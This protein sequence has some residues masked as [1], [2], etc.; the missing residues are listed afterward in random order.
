[1]VCSEMKF[2]LPYLA[3]IAGATAFDQY[4]RSTLSEVNGQHERELITLDGTVTACIE[5]KNGDA[6]NGNSFVL[7]DCENYD[8]G[9]DEV[10]AMALAC[11]DDCNSIDDPGILMYQ[12]RLDPTKC[13]QASHNGKI[14][15]G[16]WMRVKPCNPTNQLQ[17][18]V[19]VMG[20]EIQLKDTNLCVSFRGVNP[21]V[22]EDHILLQDCNNIGGAGWSY[23]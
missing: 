3:L 12:T 5:V 21:N 10:S 22:N 7:G 2:L 19:R 20:D 17:H 16:T 13:M 9:I 1:M 4:L 23:D 14:K 6:L 11:N 15:V 8:Y 18:F